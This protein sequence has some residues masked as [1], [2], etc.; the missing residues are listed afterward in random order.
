MKNPGKTEKKLIRVLSDALQGY[1]KEKEQA[2]SRLKEL[3][4]KF[5]ISQKEI[6]NRLKTLEKEKEDAKK[7]H[8]EQIEEQEKHFKEAV[9][10][11]Q[12]QIKEYEELVDKIVA[13]EVYPPIYAGRFLRMDEDAKVFVSQGE[14]LP[15]KEETVKTALV[16]TR[17]GK[18]TVAIDPRINIADLKAGRM[19]FVKKDIRSGLYTTLL[20]ICPKEFFG[21]ERI[22]LVKRVLD[23]DTALIIVDN[24]FDIARVCGDCEPLETG[25]RVVFDP[26]CNFIISKAPQIEEEI[27]RKKIDP[28]T[29]K[30]VGGLQSVIKE[31]EDVVK[32][33]FEH[34]EIF[35]KLGA[36]PP[37]SI[38]LVGEPGTGK[39]LLARTT[40]NE[41]DMYFLAYSGAEFRSSYPGEDIAKV[42]LMFDEAEKKAQTGKGAILFIDEVE[43]LLPVRS[44]LHSG[45]H[46]VESL[47]NFFYAR[48]EGVKGRGNV[49]VMAATNQPDKLDGAARR[50]FDK[51][52][53]VPVPTEE[54]RLEILKI[55]TRKMALAEDVNLEELRDKTHG[56][57]G[58]DIEH[59]CIEAALKAKE[60]I[61]D[62]EITESSL[63]GLT[64]ERNDFLKVL[65]RMR[66]S[67]LGSAVITKT[68]VSFKDI[69][70]LEDVK[71]ALFREVEILLGNNAFYKR[72]GMKAR[73]GILLVSWPG[74]GKTL[75]AQALASECKMNF[76]YVKGTEVHSMWFSVSERT[77]SHYFKLARLH[78]PSI[79]FLDELDSILPR[80]GYDIGGT[81]VAERVVAAFNVEL[82]G[83]EELGNVIVLAA[84]N[85]LDLVDPAVIRRLCPSGK[86]IVIPPLDKKDRG[87]AFRI[88]TR[89][90]PLSQD[91]DFNELA[92]LTK[93][94]RHLIAYQDR[95]FLLLMP[96]NGDEIRG[97][98]EEA[99]RIAVNEFE[100]EKGDRTNECADE[101]FIRQCHFKEAI[102]GKLE[103]E[104]RQQEEA[105]ETAENFSKGKG[106][107]S[108]DE[109][110]KVIEDLEFDSNINLELSKP[111]DGP[112]DK[113]EKI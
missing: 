65:D 48:M 52:I 56:F 96:F 77:L 67:G 57:V 41:T 88:H 79:L 27:D 68:G 71:K 51:I 70:G 13:S 69:A 37:R 112:D 34:P 46:D 104:R 31:I 100:K 7:G 38:L 17:D 6:E 61:V 92:E 113:G 9:S 42:Q 103:Q 75:L 72:I 106:S 26:E 39:T 62:K 43:S 54:G 3:I 93:E 15:L 97:I 110:K 82:D 5:K 11:L 89:G 99:E 14:G 22:V 28:V 4:E 44:D 16:I 1:E 32:L 107:P 50:R 45:Q 78:A 25:D 87:D 66:P 102:F 76:I 98:C 101:F 19:V 80:R 30:E 84:T 2:I 95:V 59:L 111:T 83:L 74:C 24:R 91:V 109:I 58:N 23:K 49:I 60:R 86:P 55:H 18:Q 10:A 63:T 8:K 29:Y 47:E 53:Y 21:Q 35:E 36:R 85:R 81:R 94:R 90:K 33:P 40:A 108:E 105:K 73:K 12:A 64:V 20:S